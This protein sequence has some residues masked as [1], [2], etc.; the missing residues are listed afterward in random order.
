MRKFFKKSAF[1]RSAVLQSQKVGA[2]SNDEFK[3]GGGTP[4]FGAI[5]FGLLIASCDCNITTSISRVDQ[6]RLVAAAVKI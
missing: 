6:C 1:Y 5:H 2:T 3:Y 4:K